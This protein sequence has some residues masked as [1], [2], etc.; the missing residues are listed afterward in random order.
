MFGF[1]TFLTFG[2]LVTVSCVIGNL[3]HIV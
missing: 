3:F 1:G 2:S